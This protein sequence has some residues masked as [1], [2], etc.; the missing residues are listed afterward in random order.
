MISTL[1]IKRPIATSLL[2]LAL[3][4]VGLVGFILLPVASLPKVDFPTIVVQAALP[5]AS[6]QIMA[7]SVATPLERQLGQIAG[8][9]EITSTS[10]QGSTSIVIQFDLSRDI[11]GAA[12][13]VQ[14]ALNAARTN[15]PQ[16]LPSNPTY[17]KVNPADAPILLLAIT[18]KINTRGQMYDIASNVLSQKLSQLSGVGEVVIGGSS[19][20][21]VRIEVNPYQ[22]NHAGLSLIQVA[23]AVSAENVNI[24]NGAI[25]SGTKQFDIKTNDQLFDAAQYQPLVIRYQNGHALTLSDVASVTNSVQNIRA[26]GFA[27]GK[28]SVILV[29]FKQPGANVI[30]TVDKI[31]KELPEFKSLLPK[32]MQLTTIVDRTLSVRASLHHVEITLLA[33]IIL[34]I[35]VVFAFLRNIHSMFI[36]GIAVI[37]SLLST[38][39]LMYVCGFS[40]NNFSLMALT[41]STGF[42]IDDAIVVLENIS[43]L[44]ESGMKPFDAAIQGTKEV[45]FT[46]ISMSASLIAIFIPL[47]FMGGMVGRIFHEFAYTL[48]IAIIMSLIISLTVTPT[49]SAYYLS[50]DHFKRNKLNAKK[51]FFDYIHAFYAKSL[52]VALHHKKTMLL[53]TIGAVFLN[54]GLFVITPKGFFP[55]TDSG[56][57]IGAIVGDENIS[58]QAMKQKLLDMM[59]I[60]AK[61]PNVKNIAGF[62]GNKATNQGSIYFNLKSEPQRNI[63]SDQVI[64]QLRDQ[65]K[66]VTGA[67][68]YLKV[69]QDFVIGG[70][71]GNAEYQYTLS[72]TNLDELNEWAPKVLETIAR[73]PG[74]VDANNDQQSHGLEVYV[75][76]N[77]DT[78]A[79][80]GVSTRDIDET[81]YD[82][83]GQNLIST[84]YKPLNQ[85]RVVFEAAPPFW[86]DPSTLALISVP[87]NAGKLIPLSAFSQF[88]TRS[89]LLAVNHQGLFPSATISFNIKPGVP[90][91]D[92]VNKVNAAVSAMHLPNTVYG[93]FQG[94]AKAFLA[95][96]RNQPYLILTALLAVYIVLGILYESWI[97]PIT[98]LSTLPSA[99]IGALLALM[100]TNTELSLVALI[101]VILLIGI[102]KKNAIMMI[103][104]AVTLRRTENLSS[105]HAIYQAALLRLRPIL[106]TTLAAILGAVPL[107][108]SGGVGFE[109][110]R[111]LGIAIIGGLIVSQLLTIY[112]TPVIY[113][114]LDKKNKK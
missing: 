55:Q 12:R 61:N 104:V 98:I 27:N 107:A 54:I 19:L 70:H 25:H 14:A 37:L 56:R 74:I 82:A 108:F 77:R 79:Q 85:Y 69:A 92:A 97:H 101:G 6:P 35:L 18:S 32:T 111:P 112:T 33:S 53:I 30:E 103:D 16:N 49:L 36:P 23:E 50:H 41:I 100:I 39:A 86:Q 99:G 34:V 40:L 109:L 31:D 1:F 93:S 90:L 94:T 68:L 67:T 3:V 7:S 105:E 84:L 75:H 65:L 72:D 76:V 73:V 106:M 78:A 10:T 29:I 13:D 42:V 113:L 22:L 47:I 2:A 66:V 59:T 52:L 64:K 24:A 63:S 51:H 45:T 80:L 57:L 114:Y 5:G 102:V 26:A 96:L 21:A 87:N 48:S 91:S 110:R 71:A 9:S 4:M 88:E 38:F 81:L 62:I 83:F 60:A 17:R 58:F 46:V 11:N 95:S 43:R 44:I 89:T 8:V 28:P 20:P 15:L